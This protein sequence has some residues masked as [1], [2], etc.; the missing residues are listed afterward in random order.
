ME[1]GS[2]AI[3]HFD[4]G[5]K[6]FNGDKADFPLFEENAISTSKINEAPYEGLLR[7]EFETPD[8]LNY[9][10]GAQAH[11]DDFLDLPFDEYHRYV[12]SEDPAER[13]AMTTIKKLARIAFMKMLGPVVKR[14]LKKVGVLESPLFDI[15][16]VLRAE[17]GTADVDDIALIQV[18]IGRAY[19]LNAALTIEDY[20]ETHFAAHEQI[21]AF[22]GGIHSM[23]DTQKIIEFNKGVR[24][25]GKFARQVR[26]TSNDCAGHQVSFEAYVACFLKHVKRFAS[27]DT[28]GDL[29]YAASIQQVAIADPPVKQ[30]LI[31]MTRADFAAAVATAVAA[32]ASNKQQK[33]Y[34]HWCYIHFALVLH[35][36]SELQAQQC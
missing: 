26:A 31:S 5:N 16:Q 29:L 22:D 28:T 4:F 6:I 7:S 23:A 33:T 11:I 19:E 3:S 14:H 2:T 30:D 8:N 24:P 27:T 17:Y 20:A 13:K 12:L 9:W 21:A 1:D 18:P 15:M 10:I 36:W 35:P 25:C 32:T 34:S